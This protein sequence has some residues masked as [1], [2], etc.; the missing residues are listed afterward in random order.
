MF[1]A[2]DEVDIVKP[3]YQGDLCNFV[4]KSGKVT[5]FDG[6]WILVIIDD[7]TDQTPVGFREHELDKTGKG[8]TETQDLG[9]GASSLG[10]DSP[11]GD[12]DLH[13]VG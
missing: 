4:G 8:K 6:K 1:E 5:G 10:S 3:M 13:K 12:G 9:D 2:G 11:L 7:D